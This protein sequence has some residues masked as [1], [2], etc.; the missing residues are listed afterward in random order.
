MRE[1]PE[2][3]TAEEQKQIRK[4]AEALWRDLQGNKLGGYSDENRPFYILHVLQNAVE[5]YG[6]R[7]TGLTWSPDEL[8]QRCD[9]VTPTDAGK[10][11]SDDID[12]IG[13]LVAS[14][15]H[16]GTGNGENVSQDEAA[17]AKAWERIVC[18]L[19][20]PEASP[21]PMEPAE[22]IVL[23]EWE[24]AKLL[25]SATA[26][27]LT[28]IGH[29]VHGALK[30]HEIEEMERWEALSDKLKTPTPRTRGEK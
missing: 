5:K 17:A 24:R 7:D 20:T 1:Y 16:F 28:Y 30:P 25:Q 2:L 3:L 10:V 6:K 9:L 12:L 4:E 11:L 23:T 8:A 27:T 18:A 15:D 22:G 26:K 21:A 19:P 13:S 14:Y 29:H